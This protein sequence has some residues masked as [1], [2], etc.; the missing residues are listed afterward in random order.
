TPSSGMRHSYHLCLSV[1]SIHRSSA[2]I[3]ARPSQDSSSTSPS[4]KKSKFHAAS[5]PLSL[6]IPRA[7]SDGIEIDPEIQGEIN[8][9]IAYADALR[10]RGTDARVIVE[11][12][13]R[14]EVETGTRGPVKVRVDR[15]T[16]LVTT[17]DIPEPAQEEGVV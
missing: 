3:L 15:V 11:T 14:D 2:A 17:D 8:E 13:D 5:V 4:C 10:D 12:V 7:L 1:S 6:P 16:H 9:C